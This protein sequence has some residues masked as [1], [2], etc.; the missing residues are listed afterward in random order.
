MG[1]EIDMKML[2]VYTTKTYDSF[3]IEG[4]WSPT[5]DH[6][7]KVRM[8]EIAFESPFLMHCLLGLSAMQL[9][10]FDQDVPRDKAVGYRAQAYEGY[11]S[12][13]Q[14][15]QPRD[16]PAL[17]ACS[18]LMA[19]LASE[20]FRDPESKRL[21][22]VDW[23]VVWRGIGLIVEI[24]TPQSIQE[25]G[26]AVLFYRPPIDLEKSTRHIPNNLLFM[27][28]SI[29]EGDTDYEYKDVYYDALKYLGSLYQELANGFSPILDL[30]IITFFTFTPR[31]FIPLAQEYRP[32]AMIILAH[33]CSF[34]KLIIGPW[35]MR[36][37]SNRQ[38]TEITESVGESWKHLLR[39]PRKVMY[40]ENRLEI[41]KE[42]LDNNNW[43]APMQDDDDERKDPR[44]LDPRVKDLHLI[45]DTGLD[46]SIVDDRWVLSVPRLF[47]E[48]LQIADPAAA[49]RLGPREMTAELRARNSYANLPLESVGSKSSSSLSPP[50]SSPSAPSAS[51]SPPPDSMSASP[52]S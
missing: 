12:A 29:K 52:E 30:R 41:A 4:G 20:A 15:A 5:V 6:A 21:Y 39:V 40:L 45:S 3:S 47:M 22:I 7:L 11:R 31:P 24:I 33:W 8:V 13:I 1:D 32:R 50:P 37:I 49:E 2:W 43:T 18:L 28:N 44:I 19:A 10:T 16:Y 35:W 36:G 46:V 34:A 9:Q 25:S 51:L 38:I 23:M 26:L 48:K 42:I 27:V 17:L 14:A